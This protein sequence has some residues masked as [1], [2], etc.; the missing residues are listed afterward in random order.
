[1]KNQHTLNRY[2]YPDAYTSLELS[3][4]YQHADTKEKLFLLDDLLKNTGAIPDFLAELVVRDKD[5]VVRHWLARNAD[6]GVDKKYLQKLLKDNNEYVRASALENEH[7][8]GFATGPDVDFINKANPVERGACMRNKHISQ[9]LLE[10][11]FSFKDKELKVTDKERAQLVIAY[12]SNS[13]EIEESRRDFFDHIDGMDAAFSRIKYKKLWELI[14]E[15]PEEYDF[16]KRLVYIVLGNDSSDKADIYK[17]SNDYL[18]LAILQG[19]TGKGI[20]DDGEIIEMGLKS[21]NDEV[22]KEAHSKVRGHKVDKDVLSRLLESDDKEA[23]AGIAHN[24]SFPFSVRRTATS[25]LREL[26][27][28]LEAHWLDKQLANEPDPDEVEIGDYS[29][30]SNDEKIS[31]ILEKLDETI[32]KVSPIQ[33]G[34]IQNFKKLSTIITIVIIGFV[35]I[36]FSLN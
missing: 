6:W 9:N 23:I 17:K 20:Y 31:K 2:K 21:E 35:V 30:L 3:F 18:K 28:D 4:K 10:K 36:W 24:P 12:L 16:V 15:W 5:D 34:L 8:F 27:D 32:S 13:S 14:F 22:R 33:E 29:G 26:G 11:L 1:M 25:R 19:S 7:A